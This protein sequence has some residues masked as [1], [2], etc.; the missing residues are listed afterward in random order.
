MNDLAALAHLTAELHTL[1][2]ATRPTLWRYD[3]PNRLAI[4]WTEPDPDVTAETVPLL[5]AWTDALAGANGLIYTAPAWIETTDTHLHD[6]TVVSAWQRHRATPAS[7][8]G[9]HVTTLAAWP[10]GPVTTT[11]HVIGGSIALYCALALTDTTN[12]ETTP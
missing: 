7:Y 4:A 5:H 8:V 9:H 2:P 12:Q 10:N 11:G 3:T 1:E 6:I